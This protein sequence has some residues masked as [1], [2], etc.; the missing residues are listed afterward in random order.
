MNRFSAKLLIIIFV[1][2]INRGFVV[3]AA[4]SVDNNSMQSSDVSEYVIQDGGLL[5]EKNNDSVVKRMKSEA[6]KKTSALRASRTSDK[7]LAD[8]LRKAWD[9][10]STSLDILEFGLTQSEF[11]EVL[12]DTLNKYPEYFYVSSGYLF[13][14]SGS[15]ISDII[16]QYKNE[17]DEIDVMS[18]EINEEVSL[19]MDGIKSSWSD[20]E[21]VLYI[22]DYLTRLCEYDTTQS[23]THKGD[24]YGVLVEHCAVCQGYALTTKYLCDKLGIE[25]YLVS[26]RQ[27]N[28]AWNII[29]I[30][31]HF[32][33]LDVTWDDP[34][35][36]KIGRS[37]HNH[38]LK[39]NNY[40]N[41]ESNRHKASDYVVQGGMSAE[42]A[43]DDY[44]DNYF[45]D[46]IK[47]PFEYINGTWYGLDTDYYLSEF[48]CD[49][50][51]FIKGDKIERIGSW[52]IK[53]SYNT[54]NAN[55][56][57]T[58][59]VY[60]GYLIYN[61]PERILGYDP[62]SGKKSIVYYPSED[63]FNSGYL[64]GI[65]MIQNGKFKC[66]FADS[67]EELD[68]AVIEEKSTDVF[69][70]YIPTPTVTPSA[71]PTATPTTV[72]TSTPLVV[73]TVTPTA[74]ATPTA[75]PTA[76]VTPTVTP[77]AV[78]TPTA[79]PTVTV[80]PTTVPTN[81]P[82]PTAKP[83]ITL[84]PTATLVPTPIPTAT[85]AREEDSDIGLVLVS[86]KGSFEVTGSNTVSYLSPNNTNVKTLSIPK[87]VKFEGKTYKVTIIEDAAFLNCKKLKKITIPI[88]VNRIGKNAF[89]GCKSL[90]TIIVKTT[91]LKKKNYIGKNAFKGIY[92]K[93]T[94]K[95]P[96]SMKKKYQKWFATAGAPKKAKYK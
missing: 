84:A 60:N 12:V 1:L 13:F 90:K 41:S 76:T 49:G 88:S 87:T 3:N 75:I 70:P 82:T 96:K 51:D 78:T 20:L 40:F 89:K 2:L 29:K 85:S 42:E 95:C 68:N 67:L 19:F 8:E 15:Y 14:P 25:C 93:A 58:L 64:Y 71:T 77:T 55:D 18:E 34:I 56:S 21:K 5:E 79:I 32:Y 45:W 24:I 30:N 23:R 26:S 31:G 43:D 86:K 47:V 92:R 54:F 50:T 69:A 74:V 94:F 59:S 73:P 27:K 63:E 46:G 53:G 16:F 80:A 22:N 7:D 66:L 39:S 36:D 52:P 35:T 72:P 44:Y 62:L 61:N 37:C 38:F 33:M 65:S 9:L 10:K 6:D 4:D 91:S 81:K 11:N 17:N 83:T 28:H 48:T 57:L